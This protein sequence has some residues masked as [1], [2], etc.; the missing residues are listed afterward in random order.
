MSSRLHSGLNIKTK[1]QLKVA[2]TKSCIKN[3]NENKMSVFNKLYKI[4]STAVS[5]NLLQKALILAFKAKSCFHAGADHTNYTF[6]VL[7]T[8]LSTP[9]FFVNHYLDPAT[10]KK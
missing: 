4:T 9:I 7:S 8:P 1:V 2:L 6:F 10:A 5:F 3:S